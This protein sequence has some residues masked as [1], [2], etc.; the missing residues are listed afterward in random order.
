[1]P[2]GA[3][4]RAVREAE[5]LI[6]GGH[7]RG[8][9]A[10]RR[11]TQGRRESGVRSGCVMATSCWIAVACLAACR[12]PVSICVRGGHVPPAVPSM[13]LEHQLRVTR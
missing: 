10:P 13:D 7:G 6:V 12:V 5:V 9:A 11:A 2:D 4:C 8:R 3:R 1:M